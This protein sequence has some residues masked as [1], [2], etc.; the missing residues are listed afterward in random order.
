MLMVEKVELNPPE[1]R[2]PNFQDFGKPYYQL[3]KLWGEC[4]VGVP[5]WNVS[6]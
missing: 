5:K 1:R 3:Q 6:N 2:T 4:I